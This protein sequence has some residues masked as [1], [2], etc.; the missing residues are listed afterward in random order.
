MCLNIGELFLL[1][2]LRSERFGNNYQ[3]GKQKGKP[4]VISGFRCKVDENCVFLGYC[5]A[6]SGN[7]LPTIQDTALK[8]GHI[9]YPETSVRNCHY[10][11]RNSSE[12]L[13]SS[14]LQKGKVVSLHTI[15]ACREQT[16]S[17][18]HS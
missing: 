12:Q 7:S 1:F 11:L 4:F 6:Y 14:L 16:H 15:Q 9:R 3:E 13:S 5:V 10:T 2:I 17:S 8:V 18:A